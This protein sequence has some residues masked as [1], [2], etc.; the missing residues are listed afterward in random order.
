MIAIEI[1]IILLAKDKL[2]R[3]RGYHA[4][5][6]AI[7]PVALARL[8]A[9]GQEGHGGLNAAPDGCCRRSQRIVKSTCEASLTEAETNS[10]AVLNAL[11]EYA[12]RKFYDGFGFRSDIPTETDYRRRFR[13]RSVD[14]LLA[15]ASSMSFSMS[16]ATVL[17][18]AMIMASQSSSSCIA[19]L[20]LSRR[21]VF[22]R[23]P[24]IDVRLTL[25]QSKTEYEAVI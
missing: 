10:I 14:F 13:M 7:A 18:S 2:L 17:A 21:M 9:R 12:A 8:C 22:S 1:F 15:N 20:N 19:S 5:F 25:L 3:I 11:A 23:S 16:F 6:K 24:R 4:I